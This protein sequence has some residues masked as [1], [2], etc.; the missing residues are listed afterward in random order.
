[1]ERPTLSREIAA[2]RLPEKVV[3]F[4]TGA[5]LRGFAEYFID[6]ANRDGRFNGSIVAVGS[7]GSTRDAALNEQEGLYTLAIR[8]M[9]N[10][11][12]CERYRIVSSL[13]RALSARDE[14]PAVLALAADPAIELVIS[15]TTEVGI[16]L[17]PSDEYDASPPRSFPGK[18][19]RFLVE[20]ARVFDF[21]QRRGVVVLPCELIDDNGTK[22]RE[23]VNE[24]AHLWQLD[25]RFTRWL[26]RAVV[27]CN[28][29]VDRIVPGAPTPDEAEQI[30]AS[31][32][33]RD[34]LLTVC[35][36]YAL[37]AIEG[38]EELRARLGFPGEDPRIIVSPDI[39]PYRE[40]KVR[41]LNGAHTIAAS[42]ALLAG[43]ETVG[44]AVAD[45]RIGRFIRRAMFDEIVPSLDAP[46][47][48]AFARDVVERFGNPYLRHALIDITLY[49][50]TKMRVRIVPSIVGYYERT[51]RTPVTLAF[52][53]AAYVSFMRGE[54]QAERRAA[55][56]AVPDD[57][58]GDRV[59]AAW[60]NVDVRSNDAVTALAR[61]VVAD[62]SLWGAELGAVPGFADAVA[63]ALV[64]IV[65]YG[66]AAAL[67]Q[68]LTEPATI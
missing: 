44:D 26:D 41:V 45:E 18:L 55:G 12:T 47:A 19:T 63:D 56:R 49:H 31:L 40:R 58:E 1:M 36:P 50:T 52:G 46:N 9:E 13:S 29:L 15:N 2:V 38:G 11:E 10:G 25:S 59:H 27:F 4:G 7:T 33:Y 21:D 64:R 20:R 14:W 43:L 8:G 61:A 6:E 51:G 68:Q 5:F 32:G 60:Q 48:A 42:A 54:R 3:Q 23:V 24:L 16:A 35:E 34:G 53:F 37:F 65:R 30:E 28:T 66:L 62:S 22:L 17:D 39:R 67:D 57:P